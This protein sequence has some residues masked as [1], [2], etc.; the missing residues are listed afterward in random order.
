MSWLTSEIDAYHDGVPCPE[1]LAAALRGSE[2]LV[3]LVDGDLPMCVADRGLV[4]ICAFTSSRSLARFAT[5]RGGGDDEWTYRRVRGT[6]LT[7]L[8]YGVAVDLG[9][10]R[11]MLFP[12]GC[13][14]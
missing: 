3:P 7:D 5:A 13:T 11:P 12:A 14:S 10:R 8:A 9:G 4:W 2:L 1:A 6:E